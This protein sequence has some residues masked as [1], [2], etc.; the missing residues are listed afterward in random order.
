MFTKH[1]LSGTLLGVLFLYFFDWIFY[2]LIA[3][4]YFESNM[5]VMILMRMNLFFIA[6]GCLIQAFVISSLYS[7]LS[8]RSGA[9]FSGFQ[10]GLRID[11]F[12]SLGIVMVGYGTYEI[13]LFQHNY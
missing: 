7:S 5:L 3:A 10:F 6:I 4:D 9:P 13:L 12:V 2:T 11:T 8:K 1:I